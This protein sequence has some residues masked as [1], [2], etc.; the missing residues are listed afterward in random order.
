MVLA[1]LILLVGIA[2]STFGASS[3]AD[4]PDPAGPP[5]SAEVLATQR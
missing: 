1:P 2:V 4:S 3:G 5:S